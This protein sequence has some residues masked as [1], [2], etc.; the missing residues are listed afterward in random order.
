MTYFTSWEDFAKAA[1]VLY[2]NDPM[3]VSW[4]SLRTLW[5]IWLLMPLT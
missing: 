2:V 3:K 1:E 4:K 5:P